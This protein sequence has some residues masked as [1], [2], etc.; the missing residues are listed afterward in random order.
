VHSPKARH[1]AR[2][3][4]IDPARVGVWR[5]ENLA[6]LSASFK[7]ESA[8]VRLERNARHA[9]SKSAQAIALKEDFSGRIK[10]EA[11]F[12]LFGEPRKS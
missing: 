5:L 6:K 2:R 11:P 12:L 10:P 1:K 3:F 8:S 9:A 7:P 4:S